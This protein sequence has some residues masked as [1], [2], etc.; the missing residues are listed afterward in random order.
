MSVVA[1]A[2]LAVFALVAGALAA[3]VGSPQPVL[4]GDEVTAVNLAEWIRE[5]RAGLLVLD[6][7]PG[8]TIE[9]DRIPGARPLVGVDIDALRRAEIVVLYAAESVDADV[10]EALRRHASAQRYLRLHGGIA[11]WNEQVL[12]PVVRS[13]ASTRQQQ[14]FVER[15]Q[16]SRYFG[17]TPRRLDPGQPTGRA[18]SRRGC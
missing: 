10:I 7:R 13:D 6:V 18:R 14:R 1:R 15:A 5:Q 9:R 2:T 12:F 17:G 16:L 3:I 8:H 4:A 11:A